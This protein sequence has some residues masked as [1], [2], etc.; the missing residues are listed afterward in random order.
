MPSAGS[1]FGRMRPIVRWA[2]QGTPWP[3]MEVKYGDPYPTGWIELVD[4]MTGAEV[5][6][7]SPR[8]PIFSDKRG[9]I[10]SAPAAAGGGG[11]GGRR[12]GGGGGRRG[13]GGGRGGGGRGTAGQGHGASIGMQVLTFNADFWS[14]VNRYNKVVV[15]ASA[16]KTEI[17]FSGNAT[18]TGNLIL[19]TV[20]LSLSANVPVTSGDTPAAIATAAAGVTIAGYTVNVKSG[21]PDTIEITSTA[22]GRKPNWL[23]N[24]NGTGVTV[25]T[26]DP[27]VTAPGHPGFDSRYVEKDREFNW[28][29]A[30]DGLA[31]A[32]MLFPE[33]RLMRIIV[34]RVENT[35]DGQDVWAHDG[36][37][38]VID[39]NVALEALPEDPDTILTQV[40]NTGIPFEAVDK[41][42]RFVVLSAP[43]AG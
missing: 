9:R 31:P 30:I 41:Y 7:R 36:A 14:L 33:E 29:I 18:A 3:S 4:T 15:A 38:A 43:Q 27:L 19:S 42:H 2:P 39:A 5:T 16:K 1:V 11:G 32:G 23:F 24:A 20:D 12:G 17:K 35:E 8:D 34:P 6:T 22:T 21:A 37:Q 26:G 13:G 40:A 25:R 28:A 10:G